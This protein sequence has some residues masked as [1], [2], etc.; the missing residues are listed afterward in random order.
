MRRSEWLNLARVARRGRTQLLIYCEALEQAGR[1]LACR[2][3]RLASLGLQ[4]PPDPPNQNRFLLRQVMVDDAPL[5]VVVTPRTDAA[6]SRVDVSW[7]NQRLAVDVPEASSERMFQGTFAGPTMILGR[8]LIAP[9][10]D[11]WRVGRRGGLSSERAMQARFDWAEW[12]F[13]TWSVV[14]DR[15]PEA[16][17]APLLYGPTPARQLHMPARATGVLTLE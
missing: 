4:F 5:T 11:R 13:Q 2:V 16:A 12:I 9:T 6:P 17:A 10:R 1:G 3:L 15:L 8:V 7:K 14:S